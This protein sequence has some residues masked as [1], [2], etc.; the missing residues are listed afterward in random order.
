MDAYVASASVP[1]H[2]VG[3]L[4]PGAEAA[5]GPNVLFI[6][7]ATDELIPPECVEHCAK[8]FIDAGVATDTWKLESS[9]HVQ[10]LRTSPEAYAKRVAALITQAGVV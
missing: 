7:S 9:P 8:R 3:S 2:E 5:S 4:I 6:Y 1:P 10:H